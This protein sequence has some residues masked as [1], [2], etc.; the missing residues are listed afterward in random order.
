[1]ITLKN[2]AT[3]YGLRW[4]IMRLRKG[5]IAQLTMFFPQPVCGS[6]EYQEKW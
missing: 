2:T 4:R 6:L 1:M 3:D 5:T